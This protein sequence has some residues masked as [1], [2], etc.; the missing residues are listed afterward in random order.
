MNSP[1]LT[2]PQKKSLASSLSVETAHVLVLTVVGFAM[3]IP[4]IFRGMPSALD[5]SNH[6]RFAL[7]FYDALRSGHLYPGW[8]AESN[9]GFGDASFRF[10]PP[11][12]YY[13]LSAFRALSGN[14]YVA[15]V[16]TFGTLSMLG[17]AGVYL[18]AREFTSSVN[19]MWAGI[20]YA[21]A[22]YHVNQ[23]YQALLLAEFAGAAILPF[24]FLFAERIC[25]RRRARDVAGLAAAYALLILTHLPL[26]VISS[27]ALA[28][29]CLLRID[30]KRFLAT[31]LR[32][33]LAVVA[34]LAASSCYWVTMISELN[35]IRADNVNPEPGL[36]YGENF[37]L[38]TLSPENVNVWWM[39][40]LLL[41]MLAMFWP[42][43]ALLR[44]P[45]RDQFAN[46][47]EHKPPANV[48]RAVAL[49]L[50]LSLFMATPLSRPIWN[51]IHPLQETQFP[52]R[53]FTITSLAGPMLLAWSIPYWSG[54][55]KT[56]KRPLVFLAGGTVAISLAFSGGHII[57]E[58]RWLTPNQFNELLSSI[59]GTLSVYQWLPV[60]SHGMPEMNTAVEAGDRAVA[61]ANWTPEKRLFHVA[62]GGATEARIRTFFYPLWTAT[63]GG[64]LLKTHPD[65]EGA[66]MISVP[67]QAVDISLEFREPS[68][69]RYAAILTAIGWAL[70]AALFFGPWRRFSARPLNPAS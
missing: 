15:S 52:W 56:S 28:F 16:A 41:S 1:S 9:H 26:A 63:A 38:S 7:P 6:F 43:L 11:A 45:A 54:L 20:F 31:M 60:W 57:R 48:L 33:A 44:K 58:A 30:K 21:A 53:W 46:V 3:V 34:G 51:L 67:P 61:V 47:S 32:F 25:R 22:P 29:Y 59:P 39:N 49:L 14:W 10:Y 37:V 50:L 5:L 8:L 19:A 35:W 17:V 62:A 65:A 69:T 18:W 55:V 4:M 64:Q 42:A 23:L 70:I 12:L 27:I 40:I 66:L 24:A 13:L 36:R 2:L 68:R